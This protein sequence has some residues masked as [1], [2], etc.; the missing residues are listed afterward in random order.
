M[1]GRSI[2][3]PRR[4]VPTKPVLQGIGRVA[5]TKAKPYAWFQ[6]PLK[7][8]ERRICTAL[9]ARAVAD[10]SSGCA[11]SLLQAAKNQPAA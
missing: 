6:N 9:C 10:T 3:R 2:V 5:Q 7:L 11:H 4:I 8:F 1:L